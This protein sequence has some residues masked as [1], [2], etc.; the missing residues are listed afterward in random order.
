MRPRRASASA[1]GVEAKVVPWT[2]SIRMAAHM[3]NSHR[4]AT[5][6]CSC[7]GPARPT[8][9][10]TLALPPKSARRALQRVTGPE[11]YS[12]C[13][14]AIWSEHAPVPQ[15]AA[16]PVR[17]TLEHNALTL[18]DVDRLASSP[19][20]WRTQPIA[21]ISCLLKTGARLRFR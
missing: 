5:M 20:A 8:S 2:I 4:G 16:P 3:G 19:S 7:P 18:N 17:S 10:W 12:R 9:A 1:L 21:R 11:G 13:L 6:P 14:A 15:P